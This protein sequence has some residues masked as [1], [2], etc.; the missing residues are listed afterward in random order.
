MTGIPPVLV[1]VRPAMRLNHGLK[2]SYLHGQY[3]DTI[4]LSSF[5]LV[6]LDNFLD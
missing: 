2:V 5:C 1:S 3:M 6:L 4:Y